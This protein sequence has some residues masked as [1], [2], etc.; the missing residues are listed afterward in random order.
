MLTNTLT[1]M[2]KKQHLPVIKKLAMIGRESGGIIKKRK[3]EIKKDHLNQEA[4]QLK[5]ITTTIPEGGHILKTETTEVDLQVE[6]DHPLETETT[7]IMTTE[8]E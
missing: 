3:T 4:D 6:T 7:R 2:L 5:G 8:G 1:I